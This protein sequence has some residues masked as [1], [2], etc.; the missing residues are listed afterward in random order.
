MKVKIIELLLKS[1]ALTL[2]NGTL[3]KPLTYLGGSIGGLVVVKI[4][5]QFL[6]FF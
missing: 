4:F 3:G 1:D 5:E 2:I 6:W